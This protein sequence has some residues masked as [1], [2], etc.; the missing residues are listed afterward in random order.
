M[1]LVCVRLY[2]SLYTQ[3]DWK[4]ISDHIAQEL[5][6]CD[7]ALA[8]R[9]EKPDNG[10]LFYPIDNTKSGAD[11]GVKAYKARLK[12]LCETSAS[13]HM[14]VPF[15]LVKLQDKLLSL[16]KPASSTDTAVCQHLRTKHGKSLDQR[17]SYVYWKD[18]QALYKEGLEPDEVYNEHDLQIL[19]DFMDLQG[20]VMHNNAEAL[21]DLVI[22]D[23]EWLIKQLTMII[24]DPL[25]HNKAVDKRIGKM[26]GQQLY[27]HG[28]S[29]AR[30]IV[31]DNSCE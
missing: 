4:T 14:P 1:L 17:L 19:V 16:A 22:I 21:R 30:L 3:A 2:H 9:L 13:V 23:Q 10:L 26:A 28:S 12:T 29:A 20:V 31:P 11:V 24:R 18:V 8:D 5:E 25:L 7:H 15:A 27:N 6:R